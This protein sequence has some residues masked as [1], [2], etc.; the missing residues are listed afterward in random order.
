M[1]NTSMGNE[2]QQI[3]NR[4]RGADHAVA[5]T[6]AGVSTA[7]GIPAFRSEGGIW[8]QFDQS[9]FHYQRFKRDPAG[10]WKKRLELYE[11]VFGADVSPN[12]AHRALATLEEQGFLDSVLTQNIDNLHTEAGSETVVELHGNGTRVAC[13]ACGERFSL[14]TAREL[15]ESGELPPTCT[16]CGGVLKPDVVLFG[17]VLPDGPMERARTEA[18]TADVFLAIGSSLSVEPA[19]SLPRIATRTGGTLCLVNLDPTPL[20]SVAEFD[21]RADVTEVLP[22]IERAVAS[23]S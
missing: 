8:D 7:S 4:L 22:A 18:A 19:A 14:A 10:F 2:I 12:A 13:E 16:S 15:I 3:A 21:L 5:F 23:R 11:V 1:T 6:G 17:E 20:S 9:E